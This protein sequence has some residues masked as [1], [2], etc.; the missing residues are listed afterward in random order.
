MHK[1]SYPLPKIQ[2]GGWLFE[3]FA[4]EGERGCSPEAALLKFNVFVVVL[5][6]QSSRVGGLR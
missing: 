5:V 6:V 3:Q 1:S 2:A 4:A